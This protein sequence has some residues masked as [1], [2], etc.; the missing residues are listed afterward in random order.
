MRNERRN[1]ERR[2]PPWLRY[3]TGLSSTR[4]TPPR[5][6]LG[7]APCN[8]IKSARRA[9]T[10]QNWA[11]R[12]TR[13]YVSGG[14]VFAFFPCSATSESFKKEWAIPFRHSCIALR[15]AVPG[16]GMSGSSEGKLMSVPS[17]TF[18]CGTDPDLDA[19]G[20]PSPN[21]PQLTGV[22]RRCVVGRPDFKL[23]TQMAFSPPVELH[24][25]THF[26]HSSFHP[27]IIR[28]VC[29]IVRAIDMKH[30]IRPIHIQ[31]PRNSYGP[32]S[33]PHKRR[34]PCRISPAADSGAC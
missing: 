23:A 7:S 14:L 2:A 25:S 24:H 10:T 17:Q 27:F 33:P 21:G 22:Q 3:A 28:K 12:A 30:I 8:L 6:G 1:K 26:Y 4:T 9:R 16:F 20:A 13:T 11:T 34:A 31:H 18:I 19:S 29:N 15:I 32:M 5:H